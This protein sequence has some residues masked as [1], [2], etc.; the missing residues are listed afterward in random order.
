M[1][2]DLLHECSVSQT[3]RFIWIPCKLQAAMDCPSVTPVA[4]RQVT[5]EQKICM[6]D[7][8]IR[9]SHLLVLLTNK[10]TMHSTHNF[11]ISTCYYYSDN[12]QATGGHN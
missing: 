4:M 9:T 12:T 3:L 7:S 1:Q 11:K 5:E 6:R 10:C 2:M 8:T